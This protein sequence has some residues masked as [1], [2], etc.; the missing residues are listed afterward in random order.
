V[1]IGDDNGHTQL[2]P[3]NDPPPLANGSDTQLAEAQ[4]QQESG[5]VVRADN[6]ADTTVR[7]DNSADSEEK[8][9]EP[10]PDNHAILRL[11]KLIKSKK[12]TGESRNSI[13]RDFTEGNERRAQSLLRELRRYPHLLK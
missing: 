8:I 2:P 12:G 11:A 7:A 9:S 6:G 1:A 5:A 10:L 3:A 4:G 13:A